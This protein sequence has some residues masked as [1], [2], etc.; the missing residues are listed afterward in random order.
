[1][2]L[3]YNGITD[4]ESWFKI[5]PPMGGENNGKTED[6]QKNWHDI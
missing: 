6:R 3:K 2:F 1:M 4:I 5:S